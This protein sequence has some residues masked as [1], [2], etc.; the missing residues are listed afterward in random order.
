MKNQYFGDINDYRKY[1]LLRAIAQCS[2]LRLLVAWML[3]PDDGSTDG[4]FI[5]YLDNPTKWAH[6]DPVLF[7]RLKELVDS[8]QQCQVHMIE[9]SDLIRIAGYFSAKVPDAALERLSWFK[10]LMDEARVHDFVFLDPDNG[11]EVKSRPYGAKN[12]SKFLYWRE[13]E[14]LWSSGKSLLIYQHFIREKRTTFIQRMLEALRR[15]TPGSF[16]E[17]FSTPHVV[18]LMALQPS[19]HSIHWPVVNNV[20]ERWAGQ[21]QHWDLTISK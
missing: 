20:Q 5:S 4:K 14:A 17:A 19:H 6:H 3:T 8:N 9:T 7:Q 21:I 1:G 18:F 2:R 12:S 10:S 13:V 11:L 16:V 15:A